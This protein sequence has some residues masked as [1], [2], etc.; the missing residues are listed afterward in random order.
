MLSKYNFN[1]NP[2]YDDFD[3]TK[4]YYR[5][6]FKPGYAVQARELTQLQT[7]LQ[8]QITKFGDHVFKEG[9]IVLGGNTFAQEISYIIVS[10]DNA[11]SNFDGQTFTGQTSGA[12]AK[13]IKT[14]A[15]D[16]TT[17]KIYFAYQNGL[18]FAQAE[19][20]VCD[21]TNTESIVDLASYFGTATVFSIEQSIFYVYGNFVFCEPQTIVIAE[22]EPATCRLGLIA[23]ESVT[24]SSTDTSLLD[25][26]L[27]SYNYSAPGADRYAISLEL[28]SYDYD[29]SIDTAEENASSNFIELSRYVDGQRVSIVQYP[30][31]S[32]LEN[33]LARRTFDESGDYTVDSFKLKVRDHIYANTELLSIELDKGKAYVKGYEFE[34]IAPSYIDLPKARTTTEENEFPVYSNYGQYFLVQNVKGDLDFTAGQTLSL[35]DNID[36]SGSAIGNCR[37]SYF[38]Y[39]STDSANSVYKI[40]IDSVNVFDTTANSTSDV[41]ALANTTLAF[42]ANVSTN[43]YSTGVEVQGNDNSSYLLSI[44]KNYVKTLLTV[45]NSG[46]SETSYGSSKRFTSVSFTGNATF[47]LAT[48]N[49]SDG[50]QTFLGSGLLSE[51]DTRDNYHLV[52]TS[53]SNSAVIAVGTVLDYDTHAL[54]VTV[55]DENNLSISTTLGTT[56]AASLVAKIGIGGAAQ[57]TKILTSGNLT[58]SGVS[59]TSANLSGTISLLK[60]DCYELQS[61][62]A[63]DDEDIEYD[64]TNQ[65]SFNTGQTDTLYDHGSITLRPGFVDPIRDNV[66][67]IQSV[68]I[69]FTFFAHTGTGFCSVDSYGDISYDRIPS[70]T[71]STGK[72]YDLRNVLDFRPRRDDDATTISGGLLAEPS[73]LIFFD[74]EHYLSR[75]DKLV[76]TKERKIAL[77]K[78]IPAINPAVPT[79]IPDSMLLYILNVPAYTLSAD[80][81]TSTYIENKRYTMRD[82][83]RI[84]KRVERMEYYT[85]LSLLEKQAKD[86]S[87]KDINLLDRFKNGILVDS[88]AGHSVGDVTNPDYYCSIDYNERTLRPAFA[89]FSHTFKF[90]SGTNY[91]KTGDLITLDYTTETF[92]NQPLASTWVNLNPYN[93]FIWDG[94]LSMTPPS[95]NWID[96]TTRPDVVVNLNGENDVYTILA[97]NVN[98]PASVGVRYNDWQ[99]VVNGVSQNQTQKETS[100]ATTITTSTTVSQQLFRTG[101][102]IKTGA[103]QTVTKDLGTKIVDTSIA[104]YIRSRLVDFSAK[105]LKP[106]A[107]LIASFD[108][109]DVSKYCYPAT[110]IVLASSNTVNQNAESIQLSTN[111]NVKGRIVLKRNNRIFVVSSNGIFQNGNTFNWVVNG[112]TSGTGSAVANTVTERVTL[113]TNE[114]GDIAGVF[115][116]PNSNQ[117]RFR[118]GEKIF[119]LADTLS[120]TATTAAAFKYVAQGLSQSTERTL[121]STRVSTVSI[122]PTLD[123]QTPKTSTLTSTVVVNTTPPAQN[124]VVKPSDPPLISCSHNENGGKTGIFTYDIQFGSNTGNCGISYDTMSSIPDRFTIVWDGNSYTSGF[125]GGRGYNDELQKL[126][127]P[128][129][130]GSRTGQLIFNKTKALPSIA[131]LVV[132]APIRGTGW[133]YAVICPNG[134]ANTPLPLTTSVLNLD[135]NLPASVSFESGSAATR[136]ASAVISLSTS[137]PTA[138]YARVS[139]LTV[140]AKDSRNN[141]I[142]G[143]TV[144]SATVDVNLN[145]STSTPNRKTGLGNVIVT[146]PRQADNIGTYTVTISGTATLFS[147]SGRTVSTGLTS[148]DSDDMTVAITRPTRIDPVAQTFFVDASQYPEGLFLD[149]V[150]LYFKSKSNTYPVTVELRPTVNG[151]PSS[152]DIVPFSVVNKLPEE[153]STSV[154]ASVATNFKFE[155]PVYLPPGEHCFVAKCNT[156]EYEVYTARLGDFLL[157]NA[158][159]R[160]TAQPAIGSMFKSQNSSTWTPIQEE[161]V[162]FKLNK[163]V[164]NPA[165]LADVTLHTDYPAQGNVSYDLFF[166]DGETLDFAGTNINYYYK[167]TPEATA[168]PD[169]SFTQ[170]QLGSNVPMASRRIIRSDTGSDLQFKVQLATTD[171]NIS[172]VVDLSRLSTVLVRNVVDNAALSNSDFLITDFGTGYTANANVTIS[173]PRESG[174]VQA[175]ARAEYNSN[176]GRLEIIVT[177]PGSGYTGNTTAVIDRSGGASANAI[178][179]VQNERSSDGGNALARYITR[180]V[181]LA[182][183]FE[184]LDLKAFFDANV[185]SG[186]S[187]VVYYK[188][189]PITSVFFEQE[190]WQLME[191]ESS[192]NPSE[193]GFVEYKYKT[194][195]DTALESGE[196]FKTFALKIVMLSS[197]PVKVPTIRDLRVVALDE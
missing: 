177:N 25:P 194:P 113:T 19:T 116:I 39:D 184:S 55:V 11:L 185:P 138:I 53:T 35:Y 168:I 117:L 37:I 189:A 147:D 118:T 136:N 186:T 38:E 20:I 61:V 30:L 103:V 74:F 16:D 10:R 124:T 142:S 96:T 85:A 157:T 164:F 141:S 34:T 166:A 190:P 196:R 115:F 162:M 65:Y 145:N 99:T 90:N 4:G 31:Y 44:P 12:K 131:K 148:S 161:D 152:N 191:L 52:V 127:Y 87:I 110:E 82:I 1:L 182:P 174:G 109:V 114:F 139:G 135:I 155:S 43:S 112:S 183:N 94:V 54:R 165:N 32:E 119:R 63:I 42:Q 91:K 78:G 80:E 69:S 98:N 172:P 167:T 41:R 137:H 105:S 187:I 26:A 83:G 67:N 129:V 7:Q 14:V 143:V 188:V 62:I 84:E 175:T 193:T 97:N 140:T 29:P 58:I 146:F 60:S 169:S 88:F 28:F 104:P 125:V 56:F 72:F 66:A 181:T 173:A 40:Y 102:E 49:N 89:P 120:G 73:S 18:V 144:S 126:G 150:D 192:G 48:V 71:S 17:A 51:S 13:V 170:Y 57:K 15:I 123:T 156:E 3:E 106:Q 36:L 47:T 46:A 153:V 134:T 111:P 158:D 100:N 22:D 108:G 64:Y 8:N 107:T 70:Y 179:T 50:T 171:R 149:S 76:L 33:T 6:L 9:S 5:I 93:V 24:E 95:D 27:G 159:I 178:V 68:S 197:D 77:I 45:G 163:C 121:V 21:N 133:K 128:A 79:D 160:I 86:E 92:V 2:Y 23:T 195:G 132:D 81:V 176:T 180:R 59:L 101:I 122:N 75:I 154:D 151:Y 130:S